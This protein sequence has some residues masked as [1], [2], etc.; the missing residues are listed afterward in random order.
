[1]NSQGNTLI[2]DAYNAIHRCRFNWGGGSALS[3][4]G[5][6]MVY[7]FI[8]LF[9]A[10]I[11]KF[12]PS[13]V[14][15]VLDGEPVS[16]LRVDSTYKANR[17]KKDMTADEVAYWRSF[18]R[19]KT[20]I[21]SLLKHFP[22]DTYLN[23]KEEADDVIYNYC[24]NNPQEEITVISNDSDYIQIINECGNTKVFNPIK[25]EFFERT[26]YDYVSWKAM[27]GD[28]SDN[29]PGV[30]RIGKVTAGKI[31]KAGALSERLKDP[32]FKSQYDHSYSLIEMR[33]D[34]VLENTEVSLGKWNRDE[35]VRLFEE[36]N[37]QSF[38]NGKI[39]DEIESNL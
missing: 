29:I 31:L 27:V 5:Y 24:R 2:F 9:N 12:E 37:F 30:K 28:R 16:R 17:I 13:K 7:N 4:D 6:Q 15:F 34:G 19:Q 21:I 32:N 11:K 8:N 23:P 20:A 39:L 3:D 36:Y 22:V 1:M 18:R 35:L 25:K 38:K 14:I 33:T 10:A 26:D